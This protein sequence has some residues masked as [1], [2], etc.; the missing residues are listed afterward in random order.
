MSLTNSRGKPTG[1]AAGPPAAASRPP[2]DGRAAG[3]Q[4]RRR[5]PAARRQLDIVQAVL[6]LAAER[7]PGAI[8]TVAIAERVGVTHGA[9]FRHFA[10]KEA[11][12]AAVFD[13][14]SSA[15]GA[16]VREAFAEGRDPLDTLQRVFVAHVG[17]VD[18][19]PGVPRILFHELQ[20][21]GDSPARA[22]L[23]ELV[24]EYRRRL[25]GL[26]E[27]AKKSG[28]V[29]P[30]LDSEAAAVLFIGTVQ[31]IVLQAALFA[32]AGSMPAHARRIL[33]LLLHGFCGARR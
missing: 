22:R 5:L 13:W 2:Q 33:P 21:A 7:D 20:R 23:R 26:F 29:D 14:V 15:L 18:A 6:A 12:W 25:A 1:H 19:N 30:A 8:T 32:R 17:F 3:I 11:I 31:G 27:A 4:A 10:G 16:V 24:R 28:Q 9:L